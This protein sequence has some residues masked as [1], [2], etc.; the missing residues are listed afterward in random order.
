M[1]RCDE[2]WYEA[3]WESSDEGTATL[4][5]FP[6]RRLVSKPNA[7]LKDLG[8]PAQVVESIGNFITGNYLDSA[9]DVLTADV[10]EFA[11]GRM[12]YT[13]EIAAP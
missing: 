8:T 7:Q 9:E 13:Y 4:I 11:D 10:E 5:V 3:L 12:Y 6:L 2:P 1:P